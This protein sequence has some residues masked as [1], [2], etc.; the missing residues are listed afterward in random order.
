[1]PICDTWTIGTFPISAIRP[2]CSVFLHCVHTPNQTNPL[3]G[4]LINRSSYDARNT[5]LAPLAEAEDGGA[6]TEA[7]QN[8]EVQYLYAVPT[9][10]AVAVATARSS[11]TFNNLHPHTPHTQSPL[12]SSSRTSTTHSLSAEPDAPECV[13]LSGQLHSVCDDY[14]VRRCRTA[15]L[16]RVQ[17][18]TAGAQR[19]RSCSWRNRRALERHC[20][21]QYT[22]AS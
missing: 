5:P 21:H 7:N 11:N 10:N 2:F 3:R 19:K 17:R 20:G 8:A 6:A 22:P 15:A 14:S 16:P 12:L 4:Q 9:R 13:S 18:A 1:M